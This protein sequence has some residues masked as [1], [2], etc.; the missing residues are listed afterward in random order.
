MLSSIFGS[1]LEWK[2]DLVPVLSLF[3]AKLTKF[4]C[5]R[6]VRFLSVFDILQ[7]RPIADKADRFGFF[8]RFKFC[9]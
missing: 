6:K 5:L 8:I 2:Q 7:I 1:Q 9:T 4:R 3:F